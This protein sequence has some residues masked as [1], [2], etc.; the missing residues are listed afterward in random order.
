MWYRN[1]KPLVD[2][3][4]VK[5]IGIIQEQHPDRCRLFMQW[6]QMDFP[7]LVDSLNLL[8]VGVV[9]LTVL[10][11]EA[12]VVQAIRPDEKALAEFVAAPPAEV[13]SV[14][15]PG[16][17]R[18]RTR[19]DMA[20]NMMLFGDGNSLNETIEMYEQQCAALPDD[21][22]A[23]FRLGVAY[24]KRF[25]NAEMRQEGDFTRSIEQWE[26]ALALNPNQ[27]IWRRRIQQYGPRLDKPY[28]FYDWVSQAQQEITARGEEPVQLSVQ[29]S[30]AEV[31]KPVR[32]RD[33]EKEGETR[34][35]DQPDA[36][37]EIDRD[38]HHLFAIE[39][40]V[41]PD[42]GRGRRA[43]RVHILL[44]PSADAQAKWNDEAGPSVV[45]IDPPK[46]WTVDHRLFTL[47]PSASGD[48]T[49]SVEFEARRGESEES[50]E[51]NGRASSATAHGYALYNVCYGPD[52]TC[53]YLR[54]DFSIPLS[55]GE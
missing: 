13:P 45:W 49:R 26:R 16:A 29:L 30:G 21:G 4:K 7:I 1:N 15:P 23:H 27:Y 44:T 32:S 14:P 55:S 36:K 19:L 51:G 25:D 33:P 53:T 10:I 43:V 8:D 12:G 24:R 22:R 54:R 47:T 18:T 31:A 5:T 9:P 52:G 3:G 28:P 38:E 11:D 37:G 41:V 40:V 34:T 39:P 46:G 20:N 48:L 17:A 2:Q 42:T 35:E 50:A 6:Q